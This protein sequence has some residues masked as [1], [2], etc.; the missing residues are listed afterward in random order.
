MS[1]ARGAGFGGPLPLAWADIAAW[2]RLTDTRLSGYE[3]R[4]LRRMDAAFM[5][6]LGE[7]ERRRAR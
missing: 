2:A 7:R 4:L 1:A 3:V 5:Q 6:V